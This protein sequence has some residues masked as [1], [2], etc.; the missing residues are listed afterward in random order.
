MRC[1][2][3]YHEE[4]KVIDKRESGLNHEVTRRRRECLSC[5][6][7][8]T[9]YETVEQIEITIVKKDGSRE[10]FDRNKILVGIAKACEKRPIT[11]EEMEKAT[12][13]IKTELVNR[14]QNELASTEIGELIMQKLKEIDKVAYIRFASVYRDFTDVKEFEKELKEL[15]RGNNKKNLGKE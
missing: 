11:R 6:K 7:R 14:G 9:T 10:M 13:E 2:Y 5:A 8:F 1:P 15:L 4:S 3:C 12:D